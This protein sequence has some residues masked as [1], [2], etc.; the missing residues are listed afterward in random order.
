MAIVS[1]IYEN[2]FPDRA[3]QGLSKAIIWS[4]LR[5]MWQTVRDMIKI[6][7]ILLTYY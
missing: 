5:D 2:E 4:M 7:L 3:S 1:E 6:K